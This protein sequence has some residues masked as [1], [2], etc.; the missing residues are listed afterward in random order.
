MPH[1]RMLNASS[2][3]LHHLMLLVFAVSAG[4]AISR[5][6]AFNYVDGVFATA[7]VLVVAGL[8]SELVILRQ[9]NWLRFHDRRFQ[10]T[11]RCLL[12]VTIASYFIV[13]LA[14]H[15]NDWLATD[16]S[17]FE[18]WAAVPQMMLQ[19]AWFSCLMLNAPLRM[20]RRFEIPMLALS[21]LVL[22]LMLYDTYFVF[23]VQSAV[24]AM[25]VSMYLGQF[26]PAS[27]YAIDS[28]SMYAGVD[29][30]WRAR[31]QRFAIA[32]VF[33]LIPFLVLVPTVLWVT[34]RFQRK[35]AN[36]WPI[37]LM[38]GLFPIAMI[39]PIWV[40]AG[41][42]RHFCPPYAEAGLR[43]GVA[44]GICAALA[45]TLF[46]I[47]I[48]YR[49]TAI[50]VGELPCQATS[51]THT[52]TL[53]SLAVANVVWLN[54]AIAEWSDFFPIRV[55]SVAQ[56]VAWPGG[57]IAWAILIVVC[58]RL[59]RRTFALETESRTTAAINP[60]ALRVVFPAILG[61][62][63]LAVPTIWWFVYALAVLYLRQ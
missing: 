27:Q 22:L 18:A 25:E 41:G 31:G 9:A 56:V 35:Q 36:R 12:I 38:F 49:T 32:S 17:I 52:V 6:E 51:C 2:F 44:S 53:L 28:G 11:W 21:L 62:T 4:M 42:L 43:I 50:A 3:S 55:E 58:I 23:L 37:R 24:E 34:S 47:L 63:C 7:S 1:S 29:P 45:V 54:Q 39:Y 40:Y 15:H 10:A 14:K 5:L 20:N 30:D 57:Y 8:V 13:V 19:L 60:I 26:G 33:G 16:G 46:S 61:T 48:S 59:F